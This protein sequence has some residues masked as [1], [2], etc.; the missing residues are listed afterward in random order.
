MKNK[1]KI[2]NDPVF[3]FITIP[4][5]LLYDLIQ[6]PYLQRLTR[7]KQLG[8]SS[9][10]YPGTQ[11]SRFQHSI[12]AMYLMNEAI[13]Q[14]R[15]LG[16]DISKED[17]EGALVAILLHDI[18]HAPFSHVLENS[19][20]GGISHEEI[21]WLMMQ[22]INR[23]MDGR[24]AIALQI[25]KGDHSHYFLHQLVTGQLDIDRLDY[26]RRDSFYSGVTE[27]NIGSDRIIKMLDLYKGRLVVQ[28]K[29]IYSIEKFLMARRLMYWQVY[30]HKT[31]IAAEQLLIHAMTRAKEL[32]LQ[33]EELFAT[34]ALRFFLYNSIEKNDFLD[35]P[36]VLEQ[37]ALLD[38]SDII[39]A[40]KVWIS[41][42]DKVLSTLSNGFINRHLFKVKILKEPLS[43]LECKE[44]NTQYQTHFGLCEHDANFFWAVEEVTNETYNPNEDGIQIKYNNG[45]VKDITEASDM[46]N[47]EVLAKEVKKYYLC[48]WPQGMN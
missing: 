30:L 20:V 35:R 36:E 27:G 34:P 39:S 8:L 41:H 2:I 28:E 1:R 13:N 11:H 43:K 3:G 9:F 38:D 25:F 23:E 15:S 17:G 21:S 6:H 40:L 19:L 32:A 22:Q 44:L 37:Y 10:V 33:G 29:G 5:E 42:P 46:F 12:G 4:S 45:D 31:S 18:G 16:Y 14:L 7:I 26:L 48:Y 47:L 24:L